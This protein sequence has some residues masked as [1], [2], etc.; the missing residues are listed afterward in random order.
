VI[1]IAQMGMKVTLFL[2]QENRPIMYIPALADFMET[3]KKPALAPLLLSPNIK[4]GY[5]V[6]CLTALASS[7]DSGWI[8]RY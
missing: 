8:T 1:N 3:H 5:L 2:F 6:I 4:N 7:A